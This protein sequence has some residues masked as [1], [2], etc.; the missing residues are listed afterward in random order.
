[1]TN[2]FTGPQIQQ[3]CI[4]VFADNVAAGWWSDLKTGAS[5]VS[6]RNVGELLMLCVSEI[7]EGAE[8]LTGNLMDDKLP[9]R[10]MIEVELADFCIRVFDLIG[11]R[12]YQGQVAVSFDTLKAA[13]GHLR[14][15]FDPLGTPTDYLL[16]IIRFVSEAMEHHRKGRGPAMVSPL[17]YAL[18]GA[19]I[20]GEIL[21]LDV[22]AA[23]AEKRAFNA[24]RADHKVENRRADGGKAY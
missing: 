16:R 2:R 4:E 23:I 5:I 22:G 18:H 24:T 12:G 20:L 9:H 1:M 19:L 10:Q 8:G 3:L 13:D 7:C 14:V 11:S 21:D 17:A 15:V 6:T